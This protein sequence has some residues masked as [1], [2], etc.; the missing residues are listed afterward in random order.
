MEDKSDDSICSCVQY[1]HS[2]IPSFPLGDADK[3]VPNGT[4]EVGGV[5]IF[6]YLNGVGHVGIIISLEADGFWVDDFNYHHCQTSHRFIRWDDP[7][8]RGFWHQ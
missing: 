5:V 3:Q 2:K 6:R 7:A 1:V 4:P 8:I